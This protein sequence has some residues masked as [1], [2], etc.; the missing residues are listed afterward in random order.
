M[1]NYAKNSSSERCVDYHDY[2]K[3]LWTLK[4]KLLTE[5]VFFQVVDVKEVEHLKPLKLL[6]TLNLSNNPIQVRREAY[7]V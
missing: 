3:G 2:V 5:F 7:Y 6:K 1:H 4:L